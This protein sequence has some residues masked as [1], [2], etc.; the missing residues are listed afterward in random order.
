MQ[1]DLRQ[2]P[3]SGAGFTSAA[4]VLVRFPSWWRVVGFK[5]VPTAYVMF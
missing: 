5:V 2:R 1:G 4:R 3:D